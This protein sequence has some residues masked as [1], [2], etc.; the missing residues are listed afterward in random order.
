MI[1]VVIDLI[2]P[3]LNWDA[4]YQ[5]IKQNNNKIYQYVISIIIIL[6]LLYFSKILSDMNLNMACS[7]IILILL[8]IIIFGNILVKKNAVKLYKKIK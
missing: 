8:I 3:K 2:N 6:I 7:I 1:L 5:A 4:E